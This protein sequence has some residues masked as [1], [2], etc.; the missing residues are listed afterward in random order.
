LPFWSS[1]GL[2]RPPQREDATRFFLKP[3]PLVL[4]FG[5]LIILSIC[6]GAGFAA[7]ELR[8]RDIN[9]AKRELRALDILLAGETERSI[10]SADLM[11]QSIQEKFVAE[12][13]DTAEAFS[14]SLANRETFDMLKARTTGMPQLDAVELIDAE[15]HLV[16]MSRFFPPPAINVADS[17]F[18]RALE[19][20]ATD[21]PFLSEPA[22]SR[23][24]GKL[25]IMLARRVT[26]KQ[27]EFIG[28]LVAALDPVYFQNLFGALQGGRGDGVSLWRRDGTELVSSPTLTGV[29]SM[30]KQLPS[31]SLRR[32]GE[33]MTYVE[34]E[35]SSEPPRIVAAMADRDFPLVLSVYKTLDEVLADWR[36]FLALLILG[37]ILC[38]MMIGII[39]WLLIRQFSTYDQLTTAVAERSRAVALREQAEAQLRQAQKLESIGQLTGGIAHDFN[40]LLTA[41][42]G[43]LELLMRHLG[44]K[45]PR[46]YNFAKNA[47]EAANR[48]ANL[49]QRLLAF[50]R[51]QPLEPRPTGLANLLTAISEILQRTLGEKIEI[52]TNI[53]PDLRP[54]L[55][56]QNQLENAILNIAIN[57]RDAMEGDGRLH[58]EAHNHACDGVLDAQGAPLPFDECILLSI[59]DTGKGMTQEVLERVFEPFFSTKPPGRGTGLGLSQVYGFIKQTG[60]H[61]AIHSELGKGTKISLYLPCAETAAAPARPEPK[62]EATSAEQSSVRI[63]VV[64]DDADVRVYSVETLRELGFLVTEAADPRTALDI[65]RKDPSIGFLLADM[66]LPD[67][68]GYELATEA[69]RLRAGLRVLYMT[70]YA[71]DT[72]AE[73]D[74]A[75]IAKPFSRDDL[76]AKINAAL[77]KSAPGEEAARRA[78]PVAP[79]NEAPISTVRN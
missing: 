35:T 75:V 7:Y 13:V 72:I 39:M 78:D 29:D 19:D 48:G 67:M 38:V 58:F 65:L 14:T 56:D 46:L 64:E 9:E 5:I 22:R 30:F 74:D 62:A 11:L 59:A 6:A 47:Y 37:T 36:R 66:G 28:V 16:N 51:R 24:V 12:G 57:A 73:G 2:A 25:S 4:W 54:A 34:G 26:N 79:R 32:M 40:N 18:F 33:P 68:S 61:I 60:G 76:S 31:R 52:T 44:G 27:G 41:V 63:L 69:R 43:N 17:D 55:V 23:S 45:D 53:A 77:A 10:Q 20:P 1:S 42:L 15:G 50:S 71:G 8:E 49:T 21:T 70:G 3:K